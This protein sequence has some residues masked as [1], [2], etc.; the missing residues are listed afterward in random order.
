MPSIWCLAGGLPSRSFGQRALHV[1]DIF[2][3]I[4][5]GPV[6]APLTAPRRGC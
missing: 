6:K 2:V 5:T 1:S 3:E 4:K